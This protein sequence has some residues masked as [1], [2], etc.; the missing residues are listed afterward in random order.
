MAPR[1]KIYR[2]NIPDGPVRSNAKSISRIQLNPI[3]AIFQ[4]ESKAAIRQMIAGV[5]LLFV[6]VVVLLGSNILLQK[7]QPITVSAIVNLRHSLV[8]RVEGVDYQGNTFTLS[9]VSSLDPVINASKIKLWTVKLPPG[10]TFRNVTR[11]R[12]GTCFIV[13]DIR[14]TLNS[15]TPSAC[16]QVVIPTKE[17]LVEYVM[18]LEKNTTMVSK[19]I[20]GQT[21]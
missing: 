6:F 1:R 18:I 8:G 10:E 19:T 2:L 16:F 12:L 11:S 14:N 21:K 17:V 4:S 3:S 5:S 7:N 13:P 9:L 15:A 20:I